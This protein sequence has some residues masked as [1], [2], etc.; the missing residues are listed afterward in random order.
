VTKPESNIT[1]TLTS[2]P[3]VTIAHWLAAS[4]QILSDAPAL[5]G[6]I[7]SR[8][9][10]GLKYLEQEEILNG[11]GTG[12]HLGGL[13]TNATAYAGS[14]AVSAD[15]KIDTLSRAIA[16]LATA[17]YQATAIVINPIDWMQLRLIKDSQGRY[18][19]GN[20]NDDQ[21]PSL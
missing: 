6:Y 18:V 1:F 12:G 13:M 21:Q 16:Q 15:S 10:Y 2:A 3:V 19:F 11:D 5:A 7:D 9:T 17:D 14:G 20:P 8:L 4:R